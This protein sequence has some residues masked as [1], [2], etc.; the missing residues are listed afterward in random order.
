MGNIELNGFDEYRTKLYQK[1]DTKF[2]EFDKK[3]SFNKMKREEFEK[4]LINKYSNLF[5]YWDEIKEYFDKGFNFQQIRKDWLGKGKR[6]PVIMFWTEFDSWWNNLLVFV[7]EQL[8]KIL[9]DGIVSLIHIEQLK[10]KFWEMRVYLSY[11]KREDSKELKSLKEIEKDINFTNPFD[12][13]RYA[14]YK[15]KLICEVCGKPG[16]LKS[17]G[18]LKTTCREHQ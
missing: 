1:L 2:E 3:N 11:K 5:E 16:T 6:L 13:E 12:I 9:S 15:S 8:K 4:Y 14:T 10:E 18:W 7:F 17:D